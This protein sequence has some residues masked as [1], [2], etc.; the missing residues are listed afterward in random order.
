MN[1]FCLHAYKI[2]VKFLN[3][4]DFDLSNSSNFL[5]KVH[6]GRLKNGFTNKSTGWNWLKTRRSMNL[7]SFFWILYCLNAAMLYHYQL[8][9]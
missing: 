4:A 7:V 9:K 6:L 5:I 1:N 3:P 2:S 8:C